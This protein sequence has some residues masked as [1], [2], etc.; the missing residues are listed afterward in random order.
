[1]ELW[2]SIQREYTI[3]DSGGVELLLQAAALSDRIAEME[4]EIARTGLLVSG[5][6]NPLLKEQLGAR[7]LLIRTLQKLGVTD[8]SIRPVGRPS[9][10][11]GYAY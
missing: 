8:E 4:V 9:R 5:R 3:S 1:M 6:S 2:N 10:G 11:G 7:S